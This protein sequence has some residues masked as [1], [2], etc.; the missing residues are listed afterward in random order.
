MNKIRIFISYSHEDTEVAKQLISAIKDLNLKYFIDEEGIKWGEPIT[1]EIEEHLKHSTHQI[2][3]VTKSSVNS[4]W[5]TYEIGLARGISLTENIDIKILPFLSG[6][7]IDLPDFLRKLKYIDSI[8]KLKEYFRDELKEPP[9]SMQSLLSMPINGKTLRAYTK[10]KYP[11]LKVSDVWQTRMLQD[12][13]S[14]KYRKIE[15]IHLAIDS[16][17][18]AVDKYSKDKPELF[19]SGTGFITKSLGFFDPDFRRQHPFGKSSRRAFDKYKVL[20]EKV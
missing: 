6:R 18:T 4:H 12:L 8:E 13:D 9:S 1:E 2:V 17:K 11:N 19:K 14:D 5:V 15:D 10:L 3:I 7:N 20:I 16:T